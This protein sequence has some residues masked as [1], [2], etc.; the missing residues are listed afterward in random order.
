V[1]VYRSGNTVPELFDVTFEIGEGGLGGGSA[2]NPGA[3]G[4]T[5]EM[6]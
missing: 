1:G 5:A 6:N 3:L 2:G 4:A